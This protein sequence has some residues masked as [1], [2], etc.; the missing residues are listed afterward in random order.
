MPDAQILQLDFANL[1]VQDKMFP[2]NKR[3]TWDDNTALTHR[4]SH[5]IKETKVN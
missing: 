4:Q 2:T 5:D 3:M 1:Q